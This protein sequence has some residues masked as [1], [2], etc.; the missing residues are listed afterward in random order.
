MNFMEAVKAMKE[1]K[2]VR[3][4]TYT[5]RLYSELGDSTIYASE[6]FE[7]TDWEIYKEEMP[8][9]TEKASERKKC[10]Y[11]NTG[12]LH[13]HIV[14]IDKGIIEYIRSLGEFKDLPI[15]VEET[16][17]EDNWNLADKRPIIIDGIK[18]FI[19]KVKEDSKQAF[20]NGMNDY[21]EL[22]E[23]IDKRS[24]KL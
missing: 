5:S 11:C 18:T 4:P 12:R 1:G 10:P 22:N 13:K 3:R 17:K 7:A 9:I 23:I 24:G 2:K 19:Q 20:R 21:Q 8:I 15:D 16:K 14:T 6:D